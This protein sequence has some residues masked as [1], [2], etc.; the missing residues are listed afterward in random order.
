MYLRSLAFVCAIGIGAATFAAA[1][2]QP[3][4]DA[5]LELVL[6]RAASYVATFVDQFSNVVAEEKY[7]QSSTQYLLS[8]S[9][10]SGRGG[11]GGMGASISS[12]MTETRIRHRELKSDFLL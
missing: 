1:G 10:A 11:R 6:E 12:E 9:P 7:S 8:F 5:S 3:E 4:T 2:Q